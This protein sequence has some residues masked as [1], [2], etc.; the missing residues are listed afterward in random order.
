[1]FRYTKC[2]QNDPNRILS[3]RANHLSG[4]LCY[5]MTSRDT[6]MKVLRI[7]G[8]ARL[9]AAPAANGSSLEWIKMRNAIARFRRPEIS[10]D[11]LWLIDVNVSLLALP[12]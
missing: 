11:K 6:K 7:A 9:L 5:Q 12:C 8:A 3:T 4:V 1:M 10:F 2:I